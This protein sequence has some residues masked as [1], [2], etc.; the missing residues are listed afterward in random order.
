MRSGDTSVLGCD[1]TN[2][3][4]SFVQKRDGLADE[5]KVVAGDGHTNFPIRTPLPS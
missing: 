2:Y 4:Q 1:F 5:A 3:L